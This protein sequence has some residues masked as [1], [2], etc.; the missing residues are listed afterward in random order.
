MSFTK[1]F[2]CSG[3]DHSEAKLYEMNTSNKFAEIDVP[4]WISDNSHVKKP[5]L[6]LGHQPLSSLESETQ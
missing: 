3:K 6:F 4:Y 5:A 2:I 1:P